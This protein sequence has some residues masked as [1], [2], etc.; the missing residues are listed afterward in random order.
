MSRFFRSEQ[1]DG[2]TGDEAF[3]TTWRDAG[4]KKRMPGL[5]IKHGIGKHR[6]GRPYLLALLV[7][8]GVLAAGC[9]NGTYPVDLFYEMHYQQSYQSHE[10][11]RLTA[12]AGSVPITGVG[13][14]LAENPIPGERVEEGAGLFVTNCSFCHGLNGRGDGPVLQTMINNY[15]FDEGTK[16]GY[17]AHPA[18][19]PDLTS[20][21]L[22]THAA[23]DATNDAILYTWITN[24]ATV[25]PA[26]G[27][28]LS[29]E[30][31]WLLVNYIRTLQQN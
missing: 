18:L 3:Q 23:G 11:P 27:K 31:R 19:S 9:A 24:G 22:P 20:S 5:S 16:A 4:G 25:M 15:P 10:P 2:R 13:L 28:L 26:F 21:E 30:E 8:V 7:L 29:V 12:P 1:Q 6:I 14:D 17:Q